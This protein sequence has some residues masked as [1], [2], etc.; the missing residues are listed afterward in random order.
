MIFRFIAA[1]LLAV[2]SL[3]VQAQ[4]TTFTYQGY[5]TEAGTAAEGEFDFELALY[6]VDAGGSPIDV[7]AFDD[8]TVTGGLFELPADFT[9]APFEAGGSYWVEA[10]VRDGASIGAFTP[11][12]PRQAVNASPYAIAAQAVI[13]PLDVAGDANVQGALSVVGDITTTGEVRAG[14]IEADEMA[15]DGPVD[16]TGGVAIQRFGDDV[17]L[18]V[19]ND[20]PTQPAARVIGDLELDGE[21]RCA[22]GCITPSVLAFPVLAD[23]AQI[24]TVVESRSVGAGLTSELVAS[25]PTSEHVPVFADCPSLRPNMV[26]VAHEWQN[27][28]DTSLPVRFSCFYKN[29]GGTPENVD[30][31]IYCL[32]PLP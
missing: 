26:A 12:L 13:A 32:P 1:A 4:T 11:L 3:C 23:R 19:G 10:R 28:A 22:G 9:G 17:A 8:V 20:G 24:V 7:N 15:S 18:V 14:R 6:N 16:F 2:A 31:R 30:T 21:L 27:L 5:L 25:C 29:S